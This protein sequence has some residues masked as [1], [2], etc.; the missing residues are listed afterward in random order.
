MSDIDNSSSCNK[1]T[2]PYNNVAPERSNWRDQWI[3]NRHRDFG[4]RAPFTDIDFMGFEYDNNNPI[5]LIEYKHC[6]ANIKLNGSPIQLQLNV[7]NKLEI[8]FFVVAYYP[9]YH[10]FYVIPMNDIAKSIPQCNAPKV[11]TERNFVKL[12]YWMRKKNCP[13][14]VLDNMWNSKLPH[15]AIP[16]KI[17]Y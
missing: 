1:I 11:W 10:N 2:L 4:W 17:S 15:N 9:D 12:L 7:A 8:P 5:A 3:S 14:N 6:H 16:L 13:Q